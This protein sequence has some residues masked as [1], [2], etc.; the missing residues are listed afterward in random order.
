MQYI[1]WVEKYR[2]KSID[3]IV[4]N[5]TTKSIINKI[6]NEN[7]VLNIL[8]YGFPGTGKTTTIL[9]LVNQLSSH[10]SMVIHLNASDE[11]GID[12]I[13]NQILSFV[14]S[15]QLF[16]VGKKIIVLDEVDYMTKPA[17]QALKYVI[18]KFHSEVHF[19]LVCNYISR[20]DSGLLNEF[21]K[22]RF[23]NFENTNILHLLEKI[24]VEEK[25][26]YTQSEL[27]KIEKWFVHDIR[28]MINYIQSTRLCKTI[29][30]NHTF[31]NMY[32]LIL[33]TESLKNIS[34]E[35]N[36]YTSTY[37]L[38]FSQFMLF[39]FHFLMQS[40]QNIFFDSDF[41]FFIEKF[42]HVQKDIDSTILSKFCIY[43]LKIFFSKTLNA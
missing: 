30:C 42:I 35:I 40:K 15:K 37:N 33:N 3:D 31:N 24:C 10:Q 11:R 19:F 6:L 39:F 4:L 1:P 9:N 22:I 41:L 13:R 34:D 12:V 29:L 28:S 8:C 26:N 25:I 17:Q 7:I 27:I 5:N 21:I 14:S 43:H 23:D 38:S 36:R 2:P 16:S 20:I 32:L 18:Q